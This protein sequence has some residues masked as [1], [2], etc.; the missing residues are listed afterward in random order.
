MSRAW[1]W[2]RCYGTS[3][4]PCREDQQAP[5][6]PHCRRALPI[7][8]HKTLQCPVQQ[9]SHH[10]TPSRAVQWKRR[11]TEA[12]LDKQCLHSIFPPRLFPPPSSTVVVH[13]IGEHQ[14]APS[15]AYEKLSALMASSNNKKPKRCCLKQVVH[16]KQPHATKHKHTPVLSDKKLERLGGAGRQEEAREQLQKSGQQRV[17]ARIL[18]SAALIAVQGQR[19]RPKQR[20]SVRL[21]PRLNIH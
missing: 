21:K 7:T 19:G 14:D 9:V 15:L 13:K 8:T 5:W 17:Q 20:A 4:P 1:A 3:T 2:C 11:E 18:L 12:G 10:H 16:T 6:V